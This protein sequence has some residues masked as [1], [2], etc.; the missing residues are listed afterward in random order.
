MQYYEAKRV[1]DAIR[2]GEYADVHDVEGLN[3]KDY[4]VLITDVNYNLLRGE[5]SA[6]VG[7]PYLQEAGRTEA[8]T[9][10]DEGKALVFGTHL[11]VIFPAVVSTEDSAYWIYFIVDTGSPLT[12][13]STQVN[14]LPLVIAGL[15]P[16]CKVAGSSGRRQ[17][18]FNCP[19]PP[20]GIHMYFT[21]SCTYISRAT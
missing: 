2:R 13:L 18:G 7:I 19:L 10:V 6:L 3:P 17:R 8:E 21:G 20:A 15:T 12:Y 1:N 9:I 16:G 14:T 5:I 4:D 11:R